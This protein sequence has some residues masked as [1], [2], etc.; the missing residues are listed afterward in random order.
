MISYASRASG[1][2]NNGYIIKWTSRTFA[3]TRPPLALRRQKVVVRE[4]SDGR[5]SI[6]FK[7]NEL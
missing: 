5:L 1:Q 7:G 4:W 3:L 2:V 6:R